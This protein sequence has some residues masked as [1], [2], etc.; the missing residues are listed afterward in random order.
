[1]PKAR[2]LKDFF[3]GRER[4]PKGAVISVPEAKLAYD[5]ERTARNPLRKPLFER[6]AEPA[7][8]AAKAAAP[9]PAKPAPAKAAP[10]PLA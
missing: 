3:D 2:L 5:E 6:I 10:A 8:V 9:A 1:M 4:H 7:P